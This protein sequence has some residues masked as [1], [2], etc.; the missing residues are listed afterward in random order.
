MRFYVIIIIKACHKTDKII[1]NTVTSNKYTC[2]VTFNTYVKKLPHTGNLGA[3][4]CADAAEVAKGH[5]VAGAAYEDRAA[6]RAKGVFGSGK[7]HVAQINM[8][9]ALTYGYMAGLNE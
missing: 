7:R 1:N 6:M 3:T 4:L 2:P 8:A 5:V 9:H